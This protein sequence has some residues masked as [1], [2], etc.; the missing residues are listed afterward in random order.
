MAERI[1]SIA[2]PGNEEE[3]FTSV[4]VETNRG[5]LCL[6]NAECSR[7]V[8]RRAH[9]GAVVEVPGVQGKSGNLSFDTL[10][11]GVGSHSKPQRAQRVPLL[12]PAAA[13]NGVRTQV[14][15]GL[16][17]IAGFHPSGESGKAAT[18]LHKHGLTANVVEGISE[19][20]QEGPA[21]LVGQG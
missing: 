13:A 1:R 7:E 15:E 19:I 17:R 21:L 6:D 14:E 12:Y 9:Q 5:A 10:D 18:E 20:Q 11:D 3:G 2:V 4:E 8:P 16:A